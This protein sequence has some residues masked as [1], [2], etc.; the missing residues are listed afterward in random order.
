M[1]SRITAVIIFCLMITGSS[2]AMAEEAKV[3]RI[4]VLPFDGA[5]AGDFK[6]LTDSV[7]AMISSRLSAKPGVEVVEYTLSPRELSALQGGSAGAAE[8]ESVFARLKTDYV[9]TGSLYSLQTGLKIQTTLSG[10]TGASAKEG[11]F[12]VLAQNEEHIM[13]SVE[14]LVDD[15][16]ARGLGAQSGDPLL[17][18]IKA[19]E[20]EGLAGFGTEHPEKVFKKGLYG[21]AIVAESDMKVE[22][23]GIRKSSDLPL[24]IVSM[25]TADMDNDGTLEIVAASRTAL[26]VYRFDETLFR[27]LGEY[28]F[29]DSYKIHAV[30]VAD[31][32]RDGQNE[33]YVSANS[34]IP[35]AS[36]IFTW[37]A[38]AGL[39]PVMTGIPYYLRPVETPADG[40]I[41]AGQRGTTDYEAGYIGKNIVKL[42]MSADHTALTEEKVLPLPRNV[43]L[44]D[45]VYAE[46]DGKAG[47][48]LVAVDR[49]EKLLVYDA[50]NSLLWVSEK[51]YGGSR[52]FI[53]PPK[54]AITKVGDLYGKDY[55]TIE[56]NLAFVP[57][58]LLTADLD[59]DGREEIIVGNNKRVTP[60]LFNNFR[61]YD[62][63]SV[64]CLSWQ[65]AAMADLWRT[66]KVTGYLADYTFVKPGRTAA[67]AA[68]KATDVLYLVQVPDKQMLGFAFSKDS[69]LLKY[70]MNVSEKQKQD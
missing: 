66:N 16:A 9:I 56:H 31:L 69:K 25:A 65:G 40:W 20:K 26:E 7:R 10:R 30:N 5:S 21:G 47:K 42:A 4:M 18:E 59:R 41:L 54:S 24:T 33:I 58:R 38:A 1:L 45:F 35:A 67:G 61:E 6:Y 63:G 62:G 23:L 53:G 46:L 8:G 60:K 36:A 32:D 13:S 15:I 44:F 55:K 34:K 2:P 22:S 11:V 70:E 29:G 27:K 50:G 39:K 17:A 37:S 43:K 48:E 28:R 64:V 68:G 12:T 19:D 52:N 3:A 49:H 57:T 14:E 51:D